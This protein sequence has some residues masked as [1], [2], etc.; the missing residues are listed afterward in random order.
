[1]VVVVVV[2]VVASRLHPVLCIC[3]VHLVRISIIVSLTLFATVDLRLINSYH[4]KVNF[5]IPPGSGCR[6]TICWCP[7]SRPFGALVL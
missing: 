4:F 3:L 1:M 2:V 5:E 7:F 6:S